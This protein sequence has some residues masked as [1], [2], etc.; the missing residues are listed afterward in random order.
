LLLR[1]QDGRLN[2]NGELPAIE[3]QDAHIEH[4]RNG[5]L[6]NDNLDENGKPKPAVIANYGKKFEYWRNG[7]QIFPS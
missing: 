7:K 4:F 6:H 3:F 2:D 1:W 5:Y